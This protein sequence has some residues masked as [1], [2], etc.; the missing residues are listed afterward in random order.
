[1]TLFLGS[2]KCQHYGDLKEGELRILVMTVR[3]V[4]SITVLKKKLFS[5]PY[6]TVPIRNKEVNLS[7][8]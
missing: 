6:P 4:Y 5:M 7:I 1:M 8:Q 2:W 3:N